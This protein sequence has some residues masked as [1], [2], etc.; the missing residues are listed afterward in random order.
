MGINGEQFDDVDNDNFEDGNDGQHDDNHDDSEF[1][2]EASR[3]GWQ[4]KDSY[5]G[6]PDKWVDAE[7]FV[8]RGREI[9]PILRKNNERLLAELKQA[10][11]QI[12]EMQLSIKEFGD[13]YKKLNESAYEKAIKDVKAQMREARRDG[14]DDLADDLSD[15]LE[16]LKEEAKNIKVPKIP[17]PEEDQKRQQAERQLI[18]QEWVGD[19]PWYSREKNPDLFYL[20]D[21]I[22]MEVAREN[23]NIVGTR[24]FLDEV[25]AR[26]R[27]QAPDR[28]KKRGSAADSSGASN[29]GGS[30]GGK[31]GRSYN[32]LPPEAKAACDR[33]TTEGRPGYIKGFT[34]EKY[35]AQ[36]FE[37]E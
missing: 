37:Q 35:V 30:A 32:D 5:K 23:P 11:T 2:E 6:D 18:L 26:V 29:N 16:S 13:I 22:A 36:Y 34:R 3:Y 1:A 20:A 25:G 33:M 19:N 27:R 10:Q 31:R 8:K 28:F 24:A 17:A 12:S 9:N 4:P 14:D 15:Q 21:G 7:T